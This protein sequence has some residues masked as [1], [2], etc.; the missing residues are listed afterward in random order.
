MVDFADSPEQAEFRI[1]VEAFFAERFPEE[2]RVSRDDDPRAQLE[3]A[4]APED[5]GAR[6]GCCYGAPEMIALTSWTSS[7]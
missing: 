3:R 1:Q 7:E 6:R 4:R 2:L 5:P